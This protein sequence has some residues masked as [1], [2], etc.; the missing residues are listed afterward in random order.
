MWFFKMVNE[1]CSKDLIISY[2]FPEYVDTGG[3]VVAKR[4]IENGKKVDVIQNHIENVALDNSLNDLINEYVEDKIVLI[5]INKHKSDHIFVAG[6]SD[7]AGCPID[8][9][10][11]KQYIK[12]AV[13]IIHRDLN[14]VR[15]TGFFIYI[16]GEIEIIN[17][18]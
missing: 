8:D 1:K 7:C 5:S 12:E 16:N 9:D 3:F 17:D 11:Q 18:L 2:F 15:T 14:N 13:E 10:K 4:I 6:H